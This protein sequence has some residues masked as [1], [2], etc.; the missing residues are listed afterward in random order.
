MTRTLITY[1]INDKNEHSV[2]PDL[3]LN[4]FLS[5]RTQEVHFG[6]DVDLRDF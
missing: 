6:H 3:L 4:L 5:L 1:H 2:T